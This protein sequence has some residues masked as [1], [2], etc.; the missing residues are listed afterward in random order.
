[1]EFLESLQ[2]ESGKM[3]DDTEATVSETRCSAA[4]WGGWAAGLGWASQATAEATLFGLDEKRAT[5]RMAISWQNG[6][7]VFFLNEK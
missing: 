5:A 2:V 6:L 1:M 7:I 3:L 4:S